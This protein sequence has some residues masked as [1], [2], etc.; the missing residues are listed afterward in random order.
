MT[1]GL[2]H[3]VPPCCPRTP[4]FGGIAAFQSFASPNGLD[5]ILITSTGGNNA[6]R[7]CIISGNNGN[8]IA[9]MGRAYNNSIF[10]STVGLGASITQDFPILPNGSGGILPF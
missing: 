9:V 3:F 1:R 10:H 7:T 5:G 2:D 6:V 8:G 4:T